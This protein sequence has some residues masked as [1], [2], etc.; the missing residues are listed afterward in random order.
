MIDALQDD[1]LCPLY[2]LECF[3]ES[4]ERR[5]VTRLVVA[6]RLSTIQQANRI[7]VLDRGQ[8]CET[9]T[10]SELIEQGGLFASMMARQT[11]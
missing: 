5:R 8:V 7:Y 2:T 10:F 6:H 3:T 1:Q 4:I 11:A 9:G